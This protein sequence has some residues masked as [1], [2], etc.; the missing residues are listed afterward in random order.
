MYKIKIY[1]HLP[2]TKKRSNLW[3]ALQNYKVWAIGYGLTCLINLSIN[4][5]M[6]LKAIIIHRILKTTMTKAWLIKSPITNK[7]KWMFVKN[8]RVVRVSIRECW[9]LHVCSTLPTNLITT[10]CRQVVYNAP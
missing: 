10:D 3:I 7:K 2:I 9:T 6:C 8:C 4:Y 1:G 5:I